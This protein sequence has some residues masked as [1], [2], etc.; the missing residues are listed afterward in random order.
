MTEPLTDEELRD[1][2]GEESGPHRSTHRTGGQVRTVVWILVGFVGWLSMWLIASRIAAR[3]PSQH[4]P[5]LLATIDA[6]QDRAVTAEARL[7]SERAARRVASLNE[8]RS[9]IA[10]RDR[11]RE[12][13]EQV[14]ARPSNEAH[15]IASAAL[16]EPEEP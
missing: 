15:R 13:L 2:E 4:S 8:M 12:A 6:W 16:T 1:G 5:N 9:V 3:Y 7:D 10:A 11:Y 14:F